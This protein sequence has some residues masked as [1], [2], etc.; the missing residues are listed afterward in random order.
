MQIMFV[1]F[2]IN[3]EMAEVSLLL[4]CIKLCLASFSKDF[5]RDMIEFLWSYWTS[6]Q[7]FMTQK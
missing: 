1:E 5:V 7:L 6:L 4:I 2:I 3:P